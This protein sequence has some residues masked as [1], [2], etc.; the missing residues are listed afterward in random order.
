[1]ENILRWDITFINQTC[2]EGKKKKIQQPACDIHG[3]QVTKAYWQRTC[4]R[5]ASQPKVGTSPCLHSIARRWAA[6]HFNISECKTVVR[7]FYQIRSCSSNCLFSILVF[8]WDSEGY[9]TS[10]RRRAAWSNL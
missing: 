8:S 9:N 3:R 10:T 4:G 7:R 6:P 5:K 2:L 1:V